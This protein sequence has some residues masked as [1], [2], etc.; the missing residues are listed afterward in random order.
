MTAAFHEV[1][2]EMR[3]KYGQGPIQQQNIQ[4]APRPFELYEHDL[5]HLSGCTG[6]VILV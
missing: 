3:M 2:D 6:T 1:D 5:V 4:A